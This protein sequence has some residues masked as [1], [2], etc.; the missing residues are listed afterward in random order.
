M[1]RSKNFLPDVNVWLALASSHHVHA[2]SAA[3]W[4]DGVTSGEAAFC[5][6]TQMGLLRLL[7]D[8]KVMGAGVLNQPAAWQVYDRMRSDVRVGFAVE[9]PGLEKVWRAETRSARAGHRRWT[10]A[11]LF[12]FARTRELRLVSFDKG[13]RHREDAETIVLT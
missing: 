6:V 3:A 11:Y 4:L 13:F 8:P 5:R 9:P 1:P 12:A 7:T 2:G 10:D